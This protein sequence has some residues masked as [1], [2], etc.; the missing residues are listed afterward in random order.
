MKKLGT[1]FLS[2]LFVFLFSFNVVIAASTTPPN[3]YNSFMI[4]I[5]KVGGDSGLSEASV[6][7]VILSVIQILIGITGTIFLVIIVYAGIKWMF[8]AGDSTKIRSSI[9]LMKNAAIGLAIVAFSY[10]IVEFIINNLIAI[11]S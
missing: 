11:S 8:S 1:L 5:R 6:T 10:T 4:G 2:S 3:A 9:N 7:E